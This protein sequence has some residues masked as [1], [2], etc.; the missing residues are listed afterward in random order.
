MLM[1]RR[2]NSWRTSRRPHR[3]HAVSIGLI[4]VLL[5]L[6]PSSEAGLSPTVA[7]PGGQ[8]HPTLIRFGFVS[9]PDSGSCA[10]QRGAHILYGITCLWPPVRSRPSTGALRRGALPE[11]DAADRPVPGGPML[12][13]VTRPVHSISYDS[14]VLG[15]RPSDRC[16]IRTPRATDSRPV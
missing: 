14:P 9:E 15:E 13:S 3:S 4:A 5:W 11:V 8:D 12:D 16:R 6:V 10:D 1:P 2:A 7:P